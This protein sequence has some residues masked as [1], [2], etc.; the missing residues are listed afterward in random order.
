MHLQHYRFECLGS[1][2]FPAALQL[3]RGAG[4]KTISIAQLEKKYRDD[5]PG[6]ACAGFVAYKDNEPVALYGG[7][8]LPFVYKGRTWIGAQGCDIFTAP[9]HR[10]KGLNIEL[11]GHTYNRLKEKGA[12]FSF[13]FPNG[14]SSGV[15]DKMNWVP[16]PQIRGYY[17]PT[18]ALPYARVFV[19]LDIFRPAW[20]Q[21]VRKAFAAVT[22]NESDFR[23]SLEKEDLLCVH[24]THGF[25][26]YKSYTLN[27]RIRY[28]GVRLWIKTGSDIIIGDTHFET[29]A[30]LLRAIEELKAAGKRIGAKRILFQATQHSRLDRFLSKHYEGFDSWLI[31]KMPFEEG[32]PLDLLGLNLADIDTF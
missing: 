13:A 2:H 24:Y 14:N 7:L 11:A 5:L 22:D 32:I 12:Q 1:A 9:E 25:L 6:I 28:P 10:R 3:L 20:E 26:N 23:N 17:I 21:R 27:F 29:E 30:D 16:G 18:G 4:N 31:K 8:N 19:R 15:V